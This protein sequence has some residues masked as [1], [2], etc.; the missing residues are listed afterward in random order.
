MPSE[1]LAGI[2]SMGEAA[3]NTIDLDASEAQGEPTSNEAAVQV[4]PDTAADSSGQ[5]SDLDKAAQNAT[6]LAARCRERIAQMHSD[7]QE[8]AL[9]LIEDVDMAIADKDPQRLEE[10]TK[11][12]SEFLFFVEGR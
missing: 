3:D 12:L 1:A 10:A 7:D 11:A 8:E 9:G 4:S 6:V 5:Q 2:E